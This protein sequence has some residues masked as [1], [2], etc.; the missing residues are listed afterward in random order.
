MALV[1]LDRRAVTRLEGPQVWSARWVDGGRAILS[2]HGDGTARLWSADGA[3]R[4]TYRGGPRFL[5]EADLAPGGAVVVGGG[6]DGLL[7]FWDAATGRLLW[8]LA[9]HKTYV[10]GLHFDPSGDIV[11][12]GT[13]GEVSR[14]RLPDP[15]AVIGVGKI[16]SV[17]AEP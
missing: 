8:T 7:R 15:A 2:A 10:M 14:W 4:R 16:E 17:A 13:G 12:R 6:G 11:T 5:A 3:L 1:D 9:A